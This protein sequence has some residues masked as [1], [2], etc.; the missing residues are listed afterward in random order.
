LLENAKKPKN[1]K[2]NASGG[3]AAMLGE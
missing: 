1:R 2:L 3:L